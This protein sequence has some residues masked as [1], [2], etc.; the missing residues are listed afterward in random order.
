MCIVCTVVTWTIYSSFLSL[1]PQTVLIQKKFKRVKLKPLD[2][3]EEE[4]EQPV[5]AEKRAISSK[6]FEGDEAG[7]EVLYDIVVTHLCIV[8]VSCQ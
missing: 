7:D 6:L 2:S 8:D 1:P 3:D 5:K 4:G